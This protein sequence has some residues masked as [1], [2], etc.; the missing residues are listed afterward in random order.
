MKTE[1]LTQLDAL[2]K[3]G[4]RLTE[5][6]E[7]KEYEYES[8]VPEVELRAFVTSA[9]AAIERIAGKDSQYYANIPQARVS[10]PL[11]VDGLKAITRPTLSFIPTVTGV[12]IALRD[13]VDQGLLLSLESR[14]R[15]NIP[16]RLSCTGT[17]ALL[18]AGYHVAALVLTGGVLENHLQ[19]MTQARRLKLPKKGSI[20]KYNDL[21]RDNAY[22]QS[23][24]RRIQSINDLRNNAAHGKGSTITPED[25]KDAHVFVQRFIADYPA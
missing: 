18:D 7:L 9:L 6:F 3:T 21:L 23:K 15:A 17:P 16:R 20:S 24:W 4:Q 10:S 13:T 22:D 8:S 14:L 1:V 25:V 2:I 5:S 12:L 19:K 11:T